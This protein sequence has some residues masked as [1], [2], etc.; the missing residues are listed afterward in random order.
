[1][2]KSG[3]GCVLVLIASV[4]ALA[5]SAT[6]ARAQMGTTA[7]LPKGQEASRSLNAL[8]TIGPTFAFTNAAHVAHGCSLRNSGNCVINLRGIPKKSTVKR[9]FLYWAY[10]STTGTATSLER[11]IIFDGITFVGT[12]IG[13]GPD[14]CWCGGTNVVYR[15]N[16]TFIPGTFLKLVPGN[17]AHAV[18]LEPGST[19]LRN[20]AN[21]WDQTIC[22]ATTGPLAG[23]QGLAE[24]ASLVVVYTN[25]TETGTTLV[26]DG[27]A[28]TEF[29]S[30]SG[31]TYGLGSVPTP[32]TGRTIFT[33][34]GADGQTGGGYTSTVT[35]KNTSINGTLIAGPGASLVGGDNDADW[36]GTDG[37]PLNQ[38]WDTHSHDVTGHL[39]AG[40]NTISIIDHTGG[41]DCLIGVANALTV[42]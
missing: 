1:M 11:R 34:V 37:V 42:R 4:L 16:V 13:N 32:G 36:N 18:I 20:G 14:A 17:G 15:A 6:T 2:K 40:S 22:P 9:A 5:M 35:N 26:Y 19:P 29:I 7:S 33:E 23:R 39:V 10:T 21:P 27:M 8:S 28:G 25:S 24:G 31:L 38:L 30:A 3:L 41:G 12:R